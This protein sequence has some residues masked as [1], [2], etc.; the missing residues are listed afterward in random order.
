MAMMLLELAAEARGYASFAQMRQARK[1]S[2]PYRYLLD[3]DLRSWRGWAV[4]A[5]CLPFLI[6]EWM[7]HQQMD[8]DAADGQK[9]RQA[10]L[11]T[12]HRNNSTRISRRRRRRARMMWTAHG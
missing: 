7:Y 11:G 6:G 10:R 1:Y 9:E 5:V 4:L 3:N 12:I 2:L 8:M